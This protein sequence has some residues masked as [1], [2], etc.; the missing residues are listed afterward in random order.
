MSEM[1]NVTYAP[2]TDSAN[3]ALLLE[4]LLRRQRMLAWSLSIGTLLMTASF[5][6][7]LSINAPVLRHVV[8]G[9][10]VTIADAA[11]VSIILAMLL[12]VALFGWQARRIDAQLG[13]DPRT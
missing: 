1:Q 13:P 3:H 7:L 4:R 9:R 2:H 12:S 5:F 6:S 8:Y 11:A 10:T